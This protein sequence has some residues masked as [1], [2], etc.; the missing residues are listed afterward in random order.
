MAFDLKGAL[1]AVGK[2]LPSVASVL[3]TVEKIADRGTAVA[4]LLP[5]LLSDYQAAQHDPVKYA[6]LIRDGVHVWNAMSGAV[7]SNAAAP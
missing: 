1:A 4:V 5:A 7:D 6:A 2:H 3:P